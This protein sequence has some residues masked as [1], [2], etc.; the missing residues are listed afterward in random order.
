MQAI[1]YGVINFY[2]TL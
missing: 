1:S 2:A